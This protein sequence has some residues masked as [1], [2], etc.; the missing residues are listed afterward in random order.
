MRSVRFRGFVSVVSSE[1]AVPIILWLNQRPSLIGNVSLPTWECP[2]GLLMFEGFAEAS[3]ASGLQ[4]SR[5]E[6]L[7]TLS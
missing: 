7:S 2:A 3:Q 4:A 5:V 6:D 1:D